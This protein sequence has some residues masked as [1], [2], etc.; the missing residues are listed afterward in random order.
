[1]L[2]ISNSG[3][4]AEILTLLPMIKRLDLPLLAM[5]G[6]AHSTL[7]LSAHVVL[8]IGVTSEACPLDLAPTSSTTVTMVMGDALAVALLEARGFTAEDFAFSHP[9]GT[10]GRRLLLRV[11]DVMQAAVPEVLPNTPLVQALQEI[12]AKGLGMTTVVDASGALLGIFTDGD[13]RRAVSRGADLNQASI[14]QLMSASPR[15]VT[16]DTMAVEALTLM[17]QHRITSLVV[18]ND[19]QQ[20]I[21][22][23]HMHHLIKAGL[24]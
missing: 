12:S 7:A 11:S 22:V 1:V 8:D 18:V 17:E 23:L 16:A 13:L 20:P 2:Y 19:S 9:G 6:N 10:L 15:R 3:N 4:S 21:G 14:G 24:V 5:T